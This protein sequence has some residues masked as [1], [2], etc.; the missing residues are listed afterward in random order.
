[1]NRKELSMFDSVNSG[2]LLLVSGNKSTAAAI[3]KQLEEVLPEDLEIIEYYIDEPCERPDGRFF[4]IFSS[5]EVMDDF[6]ADDGDKQT[7]DFI[8]ATRSIIHENLDKILSLPRDEE[9]LLVNDSKQSA[10]DTIEHLQ[11]IGFGFFDFVPYYPGC[12]KDVRNIRI[13]I[14]PGETAHVPAGIDSVYNL[15]SRGLD[16]QTMVRVMEH[17]GRLTAKINDYAEKYTMSLLEFGRRI[18]NVADE[19]NKVA[20]TV[21]K[22]LIGSGYYAKYRFSDIIGKSTGITKTKETAEKI[23]GTGLSVLIEGDNGTGKELFASA[24]HNASKRS[25]EAFVA[26]NLSALPDQL[27]ESELFGY[28]DGAFTGAKKGG[29]IGL[30]QQAAG[31]TIFLD[32]IGDI[33]LKMQGKLLRVLQEREIMR[34]GGDKIIPIDVRII[35]ATNRDL[36]KM[37]AEKAFR[38]DL[39]YRL[40]EGYIRIPTLRERKADIPLIAGHLMDTKFHSEKELS[41]EA[42]TML[43]NHDWPGNVR[44][45]LNTLKFAVAVCD[46]STIGADDL[47]FANEEAGRGWAEGYGSGEQNAGGCEDHGFGAGAADRNKASGGFD[48]EEKKMLLAVEAVRR[49]GHVAGRAAVL[50]YLQE[51]N[52]GFSEYRVRRDIARLKARGLITAENGRYGLELTEEGKR[53]LDL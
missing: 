4:V 12:G 25:N 16:F 13:A 43:Q 42:M 32:E 27:A 21:R 50:R 3:R 40:K 6:M 38:Q 48:D 44:E 33:S 15:G 29:K 2:R 28:E 47:P 8:V 36:K 39:Y 11:N 10:Y 45:L 22:E 46:G 14:T 18:S 17:Y 1:V 52:P 35:A 53:I 24:I 34:V 20:R 51:R 19:A 30:F 26:I 23:A 5:Q 37:I 31:G 7:E 49:S 9:I 41:A